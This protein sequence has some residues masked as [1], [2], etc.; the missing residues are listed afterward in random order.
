MLNAILSAAALRRV[1]TE[2]P[3]QRLLPHG[4][5]WGQRVPDVPAMHDELVEYDRNIPPAAD[6][7]ATGAESRDVAER[8]TEIVMHRAMR[9]KSSSRLTASDLQT[10]MRVVQSNGALAADRQALLGIARRHTERRLQSLRITRGIL[11]AGMACGDLSWSF[12]GVQTGTIDFGMPAA[13]KA[14]PGQ[15]WRLNNGSINVNEGLLRPGP[16]HEH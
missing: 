9:L 7:L 6:I 16:S 15:Y 2:V 12:G 4:G 1:V 14:T 13:L 8:P 11:L 5:P 10:L 3:D